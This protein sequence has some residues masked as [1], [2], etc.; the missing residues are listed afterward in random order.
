MDFEFTEDEKM[1][2]DSI[3]DFLEK[4]F[5]PIADERDKKGPMTKE[6]AIDVMKKFKKIG[7]A[8]DPESTKA[9]F[10]EDPVIFGIV[11]EEMGRVWASLLPLF[12][13]SALPA[14]FAPLASDETKDRLMPKL[15]R[16]EFIGCFAETEPEAGCDTSD[17]KTTAKL[18]G[19]HYIING[20]KTWISNGTIAD[21]ALVGA[22]DLSTGVESFFLVEK[23]VSPF[24]TNEL[25]K[26]GWKANPTAEMFFENC[27][28]AKENEMSAMMGKAFSDPKLME[29]LPLSPGMMN[30]LGQM[31]P[32]T[33]LMTLPR[34][35]MGLASIGIAQAAF[36]ASVKYAKER[37]QFGKPIGKFQLIQ[38]MLY[39]MNV[40]IET[41]RLLG[42][43]AID[44]IN[45]GSREARRL[46]SMA[47]V[48]GGEAAVK[49]TYDAMQI[50]GGT[51]LS[52]EMPL[53]RY[54]RDARMMTVPDGTSEIM[55][56]ITG[57]AILGKGFSAYA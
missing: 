18:E 55:K 54:Y 11:S 51:G 16:A 7:V 35:G 26:I 45:K 42:Y 3:R 46:S 14:I 32:F 10:A 19:D 4:E 47:K 43:K 53:E 44:A 38:E 34:A 9:L 8:L 5:V 37:V 52:D 29:L 41:G 24:D 2:R 1:F 13:M 39:N 36:D 17:I 22:K 6:E 57:Y 56:L 12:G 15:E 25:H 50:H 27:K 30:L 20:N 21:V 28:A 31:S 49:V 40:L 33:A 23:D 48:Y